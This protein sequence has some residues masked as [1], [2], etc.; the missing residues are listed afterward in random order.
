MKAVKHPAA[1]KAAMALC[2]LM[3][4]STA[5]ATGFNIGLSEHSVS[6]GVDQALSSTSATSFSGLYHENKGGMI[7][8]GFKA[9]NQSGGFRY[10]VGM[11]AFAVDHRGDSHIGWGFA[12]GGSVGISFS[13]AMR[14]EAEY[15][16]APSILSFNRTKNMKQF[17]TRFVVAPMPSAE[18]SL[19]YRNI[20][21]KMSNRGS[22]TLHDGAYLGLSFK[23]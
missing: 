22:R 5:M 16:Y 13:Q 1:S 9:V 2:G 6:F 23:F 18:L 11:K 15:Y 3:I 8:G 4:S 19:G 7:D 21:T 17:D 20:E 14:I 10:S 12:P